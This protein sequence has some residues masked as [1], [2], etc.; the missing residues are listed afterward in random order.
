MATSKIKTNNYIHVYSV[1]LNSNVDAGRIDLYQNG[2]SIIAEVDSLKLASILN[3]DSTVTI[4][5]IPAEYRPSKRQTI[6]PCNA[7]ANGKDLPQI[8]ILGGYG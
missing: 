1:N 6:Y 2:N 5:T 4:G 3:S 8:Y 7:L